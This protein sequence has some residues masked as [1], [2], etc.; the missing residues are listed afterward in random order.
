MDKINVGVPTV[1]VTVLAC[2]YME[3]IVASPAVAITST[4]CA[5]LRMGWPG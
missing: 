3:H 4:H 2:C 5:C 1:L